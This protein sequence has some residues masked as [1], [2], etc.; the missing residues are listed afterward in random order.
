MADEHDDPT[1][2]DRL[3]RSQSGERRA[4]D[5]I[6]RWLDRPLLGFLRAQGCWDAEGVAN[7]VLVRVFASIGRFE[8]NAAQFRAW[9]FT[10]ARNLVVDERRRSQRRPQA[11]PTPPEALP[12]EGDRTAGEPDIG[13]TSRI[14]AMLRRLTGEQREVL[15]LRVVAGLSVEETAEVV[16]RRPGA[17]RALQHRALATLRREMARRP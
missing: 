17:V 13:E 9:V 1:F 14:E 3:A 6:V 16:G 15:L 4:F 5:E 10:I 7:E 11:V 8:G 12:D 2:A